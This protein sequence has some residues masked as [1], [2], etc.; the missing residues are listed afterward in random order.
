[1]LC[2]SSLQ[3][4]AAVRMR[5]SAATV[6]RRGK[7]A[8]RSASRA[9]LLQRPHHA[10]RVPDSMLRLLSRSRKPA[11]PPAPEPVTAAVVQQARPSRGSEFPP[12]PVRGPI[13]EPQAF[14]ASPED[15]F[16]QRRDSDEFFGQAINELGDQ[17]FLLSPEKVTTADINSIQGVQLGCNSPKAESELLRSRPAPGWSFSAAS[18]RVICLQG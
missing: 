10:V 11:A 13:R 5:A 17:D 3:Q 14:Q 7:I 6:D 2:L 16:E 4:L 1:M 9:S 12:T 8:N 18:D 15:S